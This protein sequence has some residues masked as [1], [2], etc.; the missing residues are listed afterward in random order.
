[1]KTQRIEKIGAVLGLVGL[2]LVSGCGQTGSSE[3]GTKVAAGAVNQKSSAAT[4]AEVVAKHDHGDA[5]TQTFSRNDGKKIELQ[6]GFV[7]LYPVDLEHC[8]MAIRMNPLDW[9]VP[10]AYAHAGESHGDGGGE[11][12]IVD[13]SMADGSRWELGEFSPPAGRYC[14]LR[15]ALVPVASA[16]AAPDQVDMSGSGIY[17]SPCYYYDSPADLSKHYCFTLS[18]AGG[19]NEAVLIFD[20]PLELNAQ[21]KNATVTVELLYDKWFDGLAL[22]GYPETGTAEEKAAFKSGLQENEDLKKKLRDNVMA[23]FRA[24]VE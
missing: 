7:S 22:D 2:A 17:V 4:S 21:R 3:E 1:M 14:G 18:V 23:S 8:G 20:Q 5:T 6:K 11:A 9:I 10:K 24:S 16:T 15:V 12:G 13:V 19:S